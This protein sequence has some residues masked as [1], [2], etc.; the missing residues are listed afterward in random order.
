MPQLRCSSQH[1]QIHRAPVA[2]VA[3]GAVSKAATFVIQ[4]FRSRTGVVIQSLRGAG[5]ST[6]PGRQQLSWRFNKQGL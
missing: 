1:P 2:I 5:A 4:Q 6:L 3:F